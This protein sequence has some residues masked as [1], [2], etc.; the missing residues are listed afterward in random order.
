MVRGSADSHS[1][2]AGPIRGALPSRVRTEC[3]DGRDPGCVVNVVSFAAAALAMQFG[4][5]LGNEAKPL[6][7][8]L[9]DWSRPP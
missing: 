8:Q 6:D 2:G 9:S 5:A 4:P 7:P 3:G 1:R